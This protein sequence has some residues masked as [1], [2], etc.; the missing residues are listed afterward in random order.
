MLAQFPCFLLNLCDLS[1]PASEV[2]HFVFHLLVVWVFFI[3]SDAE[4]FLFHACLLCFDWNVV[5]FWKP[6]TLYYFLYVLV[7]INVFWWWSQVVLISCILR[8]LCFALIYAL[9]FPF[10]FHLSIFQ[11]ISYIFGPWLGSLNSWCLYA[12]PANHLDFTYLIQIFGL[13]KND[14]QYMACDHAYKL[15]FTRD[16]AV[17]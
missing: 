15:A 1:F 13:M 6:E 5:S 17:T 3:S 14:S 4:E 16:I 2:F 11:P 7:L 9:K 12:A 8:W 10:F